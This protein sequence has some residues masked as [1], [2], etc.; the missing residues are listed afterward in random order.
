MKKS[1]LLTVLCCLLILAGCLIVI[2]CPR[3]VPLDQCSS[4]YRHYAEMPGIDAT[5]IKDYKVND[6][7]AVDVTLLEARDAAG[8]ETLKRDFAV[9]ELDA[10]LQQFI[11]NGEDLIFSHKIAKNGKS[12]NAQADTAKYDVLASSYYSHTLT[13]FHTHNN[14]EIHA[15]F[16]HDYGES[17]NS[18]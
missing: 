1:W 3:T 8:W 10:E 6:T 5:F 16:H 18:K 9:P 15:I 7:V 12:L 17:I 4:I 11:D 14:D 13:V 2:R